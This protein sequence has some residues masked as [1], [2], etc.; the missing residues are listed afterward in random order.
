MEPKP[1]RHEVEEYYR[2]YDNDQMYLGYA[3]GLRGVGVVCLLLFL[4]WP[5]GWIRSRDWPKAP[6]ADRVLVEDGMRF[7]FYGY[8]VGGEFHPLRDHY[9]GGNPPA[10][11]G[12]PAAARA[13]EVFYDPA[14]PA[15]HVVSRSP[16]WMTLLLPV[17]AWFAF[18]G[19]RRLKASVSR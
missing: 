6:A 8:E 4:L 10:V 5:L 1:G 13:A 2:R 14:E 19:A 9:F 15:E 17:L 16:S 18:R 3:W 7:E 12:L 11:F